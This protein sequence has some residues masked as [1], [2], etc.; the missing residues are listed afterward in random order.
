M[1]SAPNHRQPLSGNKI[2]LLFLVPLVLISCGAF[3]KATPTAWPDDDVIVVKPKTDPHP[4]KDTEI[5]KNTDKPSKS[6]PK[7]DEVL[8]YH[9]V[10]F[11][12]ETFNAP[13]HKNK[14]EIAVLLP[15]HLAGNNSSS[16]LRRAD[17]MLEYYQGMKLALSNIEKL[18]SSYTIRF[19]DTEND[20]NKLKE[21]LKKPELERVDL[22]I[23]PTD[24]LQVKIAAYFARKREIPLF[25]PLTSVEELWSNNPF[26]FILNPSDRM[27][28]QDFLRYYKKN[29]PGESLLIVRDG[30][31][32]DLSFGEALV[33]E[34]KA[35]KISFSTVEYMR[36]IKWG[37]YLGSDK[38][39]VV[40]TTQ[41]KTNLNYSVTSLLGRAGKITLVGPDKWF[42]FS[43]VDYNQWA[44]LNVS[45]ISTSKMVG[46]GNEQSNE[47][48]TRYRMMYK[49]EPSQFT[50]MGYD[51]LLFACEALNAF[52][53][54]FPMFVADKS[55]SYANTNINLVKTPTCFQNRYLQV[56][57]FEDMKLVPVT[58]Y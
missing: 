40:H 50:Y 34:C 23:G 42:E 45:F 1:I 20:T 14:F 53:K 22:I 43:S 57:R 52:G 19:Y 46:V 16:D 30:K 4:N 2:W 35:Q 39:V 8:T 5:T 54:Y 51:Q 33:Q 26:V 31:R 27:Q 48:V 36:F 10:Y 28:A 44:K 15:F 11:K 12:G 18:G 56:F 47:L 25:S 49:G 9:K 37:E 6:N 55:L 24:E 13:V 3:K 58:N 38:T 32:F 41:D 29:H 17:L 21:I 7:K